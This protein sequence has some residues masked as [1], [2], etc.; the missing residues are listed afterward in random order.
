MRKIVDIGLA[1]AS[2]GLDWFTNQVKGWTLKDV[3]KFISDN[4]LNDADR[5]KEFLISL[6]TKETE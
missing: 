3:S 4:D 6:A 1:V 5:K 2:K